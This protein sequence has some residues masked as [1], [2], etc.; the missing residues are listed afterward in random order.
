[1]SYRKKDL[2]CV[3]CRPSSVVHRPS[4]VIRRLY[5]LSSHVSTLVH[6]I[7]NLFYAAFICTFYCTYIIFYC[8]LPFCHSAI[9]STIPPFRHSTIPPFCH[10]T[11]RHSIYLD[12]ACRGIAS[13]WIRSPRSI[14][15][16]SQSIPP[17]KSYIPART[18]EW[19]KRHFLSGEA[20]IGLFMVKGHILLCLYL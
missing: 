14:P 17:K 10:S 15:P 7:S 4:S 16:F 8:T 19:E 20:P 2:K 6:C 1:M 9:P 3:I 5:L 18:K 12:P 11:F 13:L